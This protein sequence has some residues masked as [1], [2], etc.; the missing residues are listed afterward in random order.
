VIQKKI[1]LVGSFAVGKTSLISRFVKSIFLEKYHTTVG[2]KVDKKVIS[3]DG[4]EVT[5]M[6][7]DLAGDDRFGSLQLSYLRGSAGCLLVADGTRRPT[8]DSAILLRDRIVEVAGEIPFLLLLNKA[9][10]QAEWE[11]TDADLQP[12]TA[13]GWKILRTSARTGEG[14]EDAFHQ[15]AE[16]TLTR[17]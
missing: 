7:W 12:L 17:Q 13:N 5:L 3:I 15:L 8:L 11:I 6:I 4:A 10:L 1:C 2:V 16:S 14:V 9:D